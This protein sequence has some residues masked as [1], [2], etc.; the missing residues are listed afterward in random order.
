M[1]PEESQQNKAAAT[2]TEVRRFPRESP[3]LSA[4]GGESPVKFQPVLFTDGSSSERGVQRVSLCRGFRGCPSVG[5]SGGVP[6]KFFL[7][8]IPG[9]AGG[10]RNVVLQAQNNARAARALRATNPLQFPSASAILTSTLDAVGPWTCNRAANACPNSHD[11][12][13]LFLGFSGRLSRRP[14]DSPRVRPDS[15]Y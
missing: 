6:L 2:S 15:T 1:S 3:S 5:V 11:R 13:S 8:N 10:K 9:R 14:P 4:S 7:Y 12:S